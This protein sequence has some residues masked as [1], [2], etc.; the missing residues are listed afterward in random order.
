MSK[1]LHARMELAEAKGEI[2][3]GTAFGLTQATILEAGVRAMMDGYYGPKTVSDA[4]LEV[5]KDKSVAKDEQL[6]LDIADSI[7]DDVRNVGQILLDTHT[8]S[9][10]PIALANL[11]RRT[12]RAAYEGVESNWR[13]FASVITVPDFKNIRAIRLSELPELKLRKEDEDVQY[14]T[15]SESEEGYR[16]ANYERAFGYTWEMWLNDEIGLFQRMLRSAGRGAA[17]TEAVIV[18][19]AVKDGLSQTTPSGEGAGGPTVKRTQEVRAALAAKTFQD[20]DGNN[21]PYGYDLTDV[22]F[23]TNWR[24]VVH[25]T[26]N[27]QFTDFQGGT[28]NV[29][30]NAFTPHLERMWQRVMGTDW[31]AYDNSV[32]WL[33]VAFLQGFQG[34][35]K[36]YTQLID[37]REHPNEGSFSNH[38]LGI[39]LGH[40]LGAKVIDATGAIRVK[41]E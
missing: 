31:V 23:G 28:P 7:I 27:T 8:T 33:E 18:F 30:Q 5:S 15:F 2:P 19:T 1:Y 13:S 21:I 34:G 14:M 20:S 16:I 36:T 3:Q 24:D 29:M 40:T 4:L 35:P 41:G 17:R 25:T 38:R 11:R 9:D 6:A 22:I 26:L 37:V 39:K 12:L 10:F 32:E